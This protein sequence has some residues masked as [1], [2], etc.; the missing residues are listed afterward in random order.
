MN[1]EEEQQ[2]ES[3]GAD[4]S[5]VP[6]TNKKMSKPALLQSQSSAKNNEHFDSNDP[7]PF[8]NV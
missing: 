6:E 4:F 2:E 1:A 5:Q 3:Q 7:S 8:V